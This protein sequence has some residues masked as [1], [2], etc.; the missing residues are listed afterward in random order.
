MGRSKH[1]EGGG[2]GPMYVCYNTFSN[3]AREKRSW[4][5]NN[6]SKRIRHDM[7]AHVEAPGQNRGHGRKVA[8][9]SGWRQ[10]GVTCGLHSA[11]ET[12]GTVGLE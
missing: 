10:A 5:L 8:A 11:T 7:G 9:R 1:H 4:L 2:P 3:R 12:K 6:H